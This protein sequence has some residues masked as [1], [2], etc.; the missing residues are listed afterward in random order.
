MTF[1]NVEWLIGALRE[2]KALG[3]RGHLQDIRHGA[4]GT[5]KRRALD[6]FDVQRI[7]DE[8]VTRGL[9]RKSG[10][11]TYFMTDGGRRFLD[12]HQERCCAECALRED[13]S[14]GLPCRHNSAGHASFCAALRA[15]ASV[16]LMARHASGECRYC[17]FRRG[18]ARVGRVFHGQ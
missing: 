10:K 4:R 13:F 8:L 18:R 11:D 3:G 5:I 6:G 15:L 7:A 12:E 14:R 16:A 2:I 17:R 1:M 9:L